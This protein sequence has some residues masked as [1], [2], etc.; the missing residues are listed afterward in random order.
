M[1]TFCGIRLGGARRGGRTRRVLPF[2]L[3][4]KMIVD[5][6]KVNP[7]NTSSKV[8]VIGA[9]HGPGRHFKKSKGRLWKCG[10]PMPDFYLCI[11]RDGR[12]FKSSHAVFAVKI[13]QLWSEKEP[14]L[15]KLVCP[16]S[17]HT[18]C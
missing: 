15:A 4:V 2:D 18:P 8:V 9:L 13:R 17:S 16:N 10:G 7:P 6:I 14:E 3:G 12:R 5:R 11:A 1:N